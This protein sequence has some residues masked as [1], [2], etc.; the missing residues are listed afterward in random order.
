[1]LFLY[2]TASRRF[3][4]QAVDL[5]QEQGI[6]AYT[7]E[8]Q[9]HAGGSVTAWTNTGSEFDIYVCNDED[10]AR[11][12]QLLIGIGADNPPPIAMPDHWTTMLLIFGALALLGV[13]LFLYYGS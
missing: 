3:W 2:K 9:N 10:F 5:L 6:P 1:M 12:K 7:K 13:G 4:R 8:L 11:A